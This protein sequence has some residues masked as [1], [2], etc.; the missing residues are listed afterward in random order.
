V[1]AILFIKGFD[2]LVH[3]QVHAV[4]RGWTSIESK[5]AEV[6]ETQAI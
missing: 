6:D 5:A 4:K 1:Y 3:G 2:G